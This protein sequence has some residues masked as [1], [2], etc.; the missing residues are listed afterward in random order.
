[1]DY[2][3]RGFPERELQG[4][5]S[6]GGAVQA[7]D[8]SQCQHV[9]YHLEPHQSLSHVTEQEVQRLHGDQVPRGHTKVGF[10]IMILC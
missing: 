2:G 4:Q 8:Q 5:L 6:A 1:V 9:T 3:I 7:Q 10:I